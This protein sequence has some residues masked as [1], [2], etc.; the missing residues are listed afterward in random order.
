VLVVDGVVCPRSALERVKLSN[1]WLAVKMH[2]R[3][4]WLLPTEQITNLDVLLA[5]LQP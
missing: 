4:E 5:L 2:G 1:R 3:S